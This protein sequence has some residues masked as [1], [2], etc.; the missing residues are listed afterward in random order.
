MNRIALIHTGAVVIDMFRPLAAEHWPGWEVL[1]LLDDRIVADL[2]AGRADSVR[3]RL[4]LLRDAA[5]AA[6]C[7]AALLTCSSVSEFAAGLSDADFVV[8]RVDAAMADAAVAA[9][10]RIGVVATLPTTLEPT[11]RLLG[12][13][14]ALAGRDVACEPIVVPGAFEALVAGDRARHDLAVQA[15]VADLATRSEVVVLAQASM[16]GAL[17]GVDVRVPVLASPE[18]GVRAL[19]PVLAGLAARG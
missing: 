3:T 19:A 16:A 9:A 14:A 13:R 4:G 5:R 8:H 1:N 10:R 7:A 15:A 2:G 17:A 11:T 12:E 18:L 6:G